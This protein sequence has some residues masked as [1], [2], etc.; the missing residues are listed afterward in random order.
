MAVMPRRNPR[1][2]ISD[3]LAPDGHG[4]FI[5][6]QLAAES[7][8]LLAHQGEIN[9]VAA[10]CAPRPELLARVMA[11]IGVEALG[12]ITMGRDVWRYTYAQLIANL[13]ERARASA[14]RP[15]GEVAL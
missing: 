7:L 5:H 4:H 1:R 3:L 9:R 14:P 8:A 2:P 11:E 10:L 12:P 15:L 6:I 13:D